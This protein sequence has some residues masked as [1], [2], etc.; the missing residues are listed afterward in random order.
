VDVIW[1]SIIIVFMF[2]FMWQNKYSKYALHI[3]HWIC[4]FKDMYRPNK[5]RLK[6]SIYIICADIY[7]LLDSGNITIYSVQNYWKCSR[8]DIN[9]NVDFPEVLIIATLAKIILTTQNVRHT[10]KYRHVYE[11]HYRKRIGASALK[12]IEILRVKLLRVIIP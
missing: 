4:L 2:Q 8:S 12:M 6:F 7:C 1:F 3:L 10:W 5:Y 11:A 9:F